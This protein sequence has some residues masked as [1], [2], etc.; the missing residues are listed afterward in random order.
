LPSFVLSFAETAEELA[1]RL[2]QE[3]LVTLFRQLHP[4][5]DGW[6]L[7]LINVA[8]TNMAETA[9]NSKGAFGRDIGNMFRTQD[10][11]LQPWKV[12]DV[13][14]LSNED[15]DHFVMD[16]TVI[17]SDVV[18]WEAHTNGSED[19][20]PLSQAIHSSDIGD[21]WYESDD[22]DEQHSSAISCP[23]CGAVMPDFAIAAHL[24][25][26]ETND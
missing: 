25:F 22:G 2:V 14:D 18:D 10:K 6:D 24:R 7:S 26:H 23:L 5:R 21:A 15:L 20:L 11:I 13:D 19:A 12:E 1:E 8:V 17:S 16:K 9:G 4:E 3:C